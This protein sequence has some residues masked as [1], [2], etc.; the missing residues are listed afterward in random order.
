MVIEGGCTEY[1]PTWWKMI[2]P[3]P[4]LPAP[5]SPGI[6]EWK[7][8]SQFA[9]FEMQVE[10]LPSPIVA[11]L[12]PGRIGP[13]STIVLMMAQIKIGIND[14]TPYRP[15]RDPEGSQHKNPQCIFLI[16]PQ[17]RFSPSKS[18]TTHVERVLTQS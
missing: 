16:L 10:L 5:F 1:R 12:Q 13:G 11:S 7:L 6:E 4:S 17:V 18:P 9:G 2:I 14:A 8:L 3:N 15:S